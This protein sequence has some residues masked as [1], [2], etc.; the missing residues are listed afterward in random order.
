MDFGMCSP[1]A[2]IYR[3][4]RPQLGGYYGGPCFAWAD[5]FAACGRSFRI[6]PTEYR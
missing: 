3:W 2:E 4:L 1:A 5:G 6:C